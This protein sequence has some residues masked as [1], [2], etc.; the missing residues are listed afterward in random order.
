MWFKDNENISTH[1]QVC[2]FFEKKTQKS[3]Y[4]PLKHK[5]SNQSG[6]DPCKKINSN[7][8][9]VGYNAI[10]TNTSATQLE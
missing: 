2:L 5:Q 3:T 4:I 7:L 10:L 9:Y 6:F 1:E 8:A